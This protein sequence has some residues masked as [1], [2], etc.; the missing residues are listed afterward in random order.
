[1]YGTWLKRPNIG[2][3]GISKGEWKDQ[4]RSNI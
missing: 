2:E 1:M 3:S 4:V